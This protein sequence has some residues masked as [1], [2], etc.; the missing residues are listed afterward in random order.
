LGNAA[1]PDDQRPGSSTRVVDQTSTLPVDVTLPSPS[2][3]PSH[4]NDHVKVN[5]KVNVNVA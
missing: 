2:P 3:S 5:V 1:F 4:V